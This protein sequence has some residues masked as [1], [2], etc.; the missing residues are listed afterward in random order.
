VARKRLE[1]GFRSS[2]YQHLKSL[3]DLPELL[4]NLLK[5]LL[6]MCHLAEIEGLEH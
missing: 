6:A 3:L 2:H 5:L 1:K 4:T